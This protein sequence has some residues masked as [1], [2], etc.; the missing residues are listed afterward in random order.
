MRRSIAVG[1]PV[2]G[3]VTAVAVLAGRRLAD[4]DLPWHLALGRVLVSEGRIPRTDPLAYTHRPIGYMEFLSDGLLYLIDRSTGA[5]GLQLLGALLALGT[6]LL[7]ARA[8]EPAGHARWGVVGLAI[9]SMSTF[10]LVRPAT[11]SFVLLALVLVLISLHREAPSARRGRIALACFVPLTLA[12][13]NLHGFAVLGL[14]VLGLYAGYRTACRVARGRAK[15]FL[16]VEDGTEL[17]LTWAVT[18]AS[19]V[20]SGANL[21]GYRLLTGPVQAGRDFSR[22]TEWATTRVGFLL[23]HEPVVL[24][25]FV[26]ALV[27]LALGREPNGSRAPNGFE[28]VLFLFALL[29][30]RSA[31]RLLPVAVILVTPT[32]ARRLAFVVNGRRPLEVGS[33]LLSFAA[34]PAVVSSTPS[35]GIGFEPQQ[36]PEAA[37]RFIQRE[38][39]VG[40][41][42]NFMPYGGYLSYRL[43]PEH[44]VLVDGRSGWVHDPQLFG[45]VLS[46]DDKPALLAELTAE[47]Q[48]EWAV[49]RSREGEPFG[50]SLATSGKWT[51]VH[52]DDVGAVYVRRGGANPELEKRGY[53]LLHHLVL[54]ER[55]LEVALTS[56]SAA[57]LLAHDGDLAALQ[58]PTSLRAAF[59]SACGALALHDEAKLARACAR[60][61]QLS[62]GHPALTELAGAAHRVGMRKLSCSL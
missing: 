35:F 1:L 21:G 48:L 7:L 29:L 61:D 5:L 44:L 3:L 39:P 41:L 13:V 38:K 40:N 47:L 26:I 24:G 18:L 55:V 31:V 59:F 54:P 60:L 49:T 9:A 25:F 12:W 33:L 23:E 22:I 34:I 46:A 45:R 50:A 15:A 57:P 19:F 16:P 11:I 2:A 27:A 58:D 56:R 53:R 28:V 20:A 36:F 4:P 52:L 37:V 32:V 62:P 14:G 10:L 43:Y 17:W 42:Y 51:M 8:A 30:G 6:A